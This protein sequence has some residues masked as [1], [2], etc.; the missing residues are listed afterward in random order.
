LPCWKN[1]IWN[2]S[3]SSPPACRGSASFISDDP[4]H[5]AVIEA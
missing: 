1:N 3:C 4:L 5:T 2:G